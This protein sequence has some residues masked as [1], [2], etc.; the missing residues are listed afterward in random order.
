MTTSDGGL[1]PPW[2]GGSR[3]R[4]CRARRRDRGSIRSSPPCNHRQHG[5]GTAYGLRVTRYRLRSFD[6]TTAGGSRESSVLLVLPALLVGVLAFGVVGAGAAGE[7]GAPRLVLRNAD[8]AA[9]TKAAL[10]LSDFPAGWKAVAS[11]PVTRNAVGAACEQFKP[12]LSQQTVTGLSGRMFLRAD[13]PQQVSGLVA[14]FRSRSDALQVFRTELQPVLR[15]VRTCERGPRGWRP[16]YSRSP[17][18]S[19]HGAPRSGGHR[20]PSNR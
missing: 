3:A 2:T 6:P 9:A 13:Q 5:V 1:R 15:P 4:A 10:R 18:T 17:A 16:P 8:R 14:V 20:A 11:W 7:P 12:D 19:A